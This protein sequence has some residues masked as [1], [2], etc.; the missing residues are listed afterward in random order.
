MPRRRALLAPCVAAVLVVA[1]AVLSGCSPADPADPGSIALPGPVTA[2]DVAVTAEVYRSRIDPSRGGMQLSVRNDGPV[3][4]T[5]VG[6]RLESPALQ[7]PIVRER[8]TV[9]GPG[10]TRDLALTLT[11]AACPAGD[12]DPPQA[13]LVVQLIDGSTAEVA[14]PTVDRIGQW[15]EWVAAEC[16][17]A[18][19]AERVQL[20][21]RHDPARDDGALIGLLLDI[22]PRSGAGEA[23]VELVSL[24]DTVLFGLVQSSDGRRVTRAPLPTGTGDGAAAVSI[25][26]LLTPARCDAHALADDKQGTLFRIDVVLDGV[27][28]TVTI[29][30]DSATRAGLYDAFRRACEL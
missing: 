13:V 4:L 7:Q 12:P 17:A 16:F 19:V 6:T 24:S 15:A 3:P 18:A 27:P 30:A 14:V 1:S 21:V 22:A 28:G 11:P 2:A 8:T 20:T 5:I 29:A 23:G 9:I 10:L 25:P 26:I